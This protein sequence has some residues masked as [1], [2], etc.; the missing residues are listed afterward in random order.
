MPEED[1]SPEALNTEQRSRIRHR[2]REKLYHRDSKAS[3]DSQIR[4]QEIQSFLRAPKDGRT[5]VTTPDLE[6][7]HELDSSEVR[8][9][10]S[11]TSPSPARRKTP[12]KPNLH[13]NFAATP[14]V[15][16]G[17][18]GDEAALPVT[19]LLPSLTAPSEAPAEASRNVVSQLSNTASQVLAVQ[20]QSSQNG[21]FRPRT[22]QRRSTGLR[23]HDLNEQGSEP[24]N[25][26]QNQSVANRTLG[27]VRAGETVKEDRHE[28]RSNSAEGHHSANADSSKH[29]ATVGIDWNIR[30]VTRQ[31]TASGSLRLPLP[32]PDISFTNSLTPL[33]S[34][35]PLRSSNVSL[36]LRPS[37]AAPSLSDDSS[38]MPG[39]GRTSENKTQQPLRPDPP[40]LTVEN[41]GLSLRNVAKGVSDDALLE[42]AAR[43]QPYCN[44]FLLGLSARTE[45]TLQQW[46]IAASWWFLKGRSELE[47][48]VRARPGSEITQADVPL[49]LRQAYV[50]LAK[51]WW[52]ISEITP[53]RHPEVKR[54]E[55][56]GPVPISAIMQSFVDAKAA[57][58]IQMHLSILS[59]MRALTMSMK[60]NS[61]LPPHGLELQGLDTR[62]FVE[63][64]LLSPSAA[65]L[66]SIENLG[67]IS[68]GMHGE[69]AYT[70][71]IPITDTERHF[72]Y[73]QMF[74][75]VILDQDKAE[76]RISMPCV[77]SVVRD[78]KERDITIVAASQDGQIH[79]VIQPEAHMALSWQDVHWQT[80]HRY[81]D[82]DLRAD[83]GV[84]IQF[85]DKDFRTVWGIHDYIRAVRKQS[86]STRHE[87]L[88]FERVLRS[89]Q[90]FDKRKEATQFPTEPIEGCKLRLFECFKVI[91]TGVGERKIHDGY[92][93]LVVTARKVKTLS[94]V[95]HSLGRQDPIVFS[96]LRD[97]HGAPALLL[98]T[99]KSSNDPSMVMSFQ[100]EADRELLYA[101]LNGTKLSDDENGS[102]TLSLKNCDIMTNLNCETSLSNRTG[103]LGSLAWKRLQ[104]LGRRG[105][106]LE[107]GGPT[108]RIC[109]ECDIGS[110]ADRINLGPGELQMRL[111]CDTVDRVDIL[112]APQTDMTACFAD[113]SLSE[114]QYEGLRQLLDSVTR[115][116]TLRVFNFGSLNDLHTFQTLITGFSVLFDGF[117]KSFAITRRRMVV[118]IYKR[119]EASTTRLQIVRHDKTFQ[120]VAFFRDFSHGSCMNFVLKSTDV[121]ESFSRSGTPHLCIV[122]AKFA[123]PKEETD[124]NHRFINLEMPEYPGEHDDITIGFETDHDRDAFSNALP[125]PAPKASEYY[126]SCTRA[127]HADDTLNTVRDVAPPLHVSTTFRYDTDPNDLIP[128]S[129]AASHNT[130][131]HVYSRITAPN[132]T[133]FES[134]LTSVLN[135]SCLAYSSG[136]SALHAAYVCLNPKRVSIGGGYHGSHGVL[137]IHQ[138]LCGTELL[139][140]DCPTSDLSSGDV[141]HLETPLNPTGE[142][143]NM[144]AYAEKAHSRG[145]VLLVDATFG[146]P[147]LQDPFEWDADIVMHSGTKYLGGHS[148]M[149][150]GVL[151]TK[152]EEWLDRLRNEREFLGCVM[153]NMESWLG[154][155]SL[156]TLDLRVK[157]QSENAGKLVQWLDICSNT[158]SE[159]EEAALVKAVVRSVQHASLQ[160]ED[161]HWLKKQMP[162]GFGPVFAFIVKEEWMARQLPSLLSLFHHA[163]SLGAVESLIEWRSMS[164]ET[165]DPRLLRV[166]VGIEDWEDLKADLSKAFRRLLDRG[167]VSC[168]P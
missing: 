97:E 83:F 37:L 134:V 17:E 129:D 144:K 82:I 105:Q 117:A 81:L 109:A 116:P 132:A 4:D 98:R 147:G 154:V 1:T 2:W 64:P 155:R 104:V 125:A 161:M 25:W 131:A 71:P 149:L 31:N 123:L 16:I 20:E 111:H 59:N 41:R 85:A 138:R 162:N 65:R 165:V 61:R 42:F 88:V 93:L 157:R 130:E 15:I 58:L 74:V 69:T 18:G 126:N 39:D 44:V 102:D 113:N 80:S 75:D 122:D 36:N 13:V 77:L 47:S 21:Y 100:Q 60:R 96:Y 121:F 140:L 164:D 159:D 115:S 19:E 9:L 89:F 35:Q 24:T 110:I 51:A 14:P 108:L 103:L 29:N 166:S 45:P 136:L 90:H 95:S 87:T 70:F 143:Y 34:P 168:V 68:S 142:A 57:E 30:G 53:A 146:P 54:L 23:D 94:S 133:R 8:S 66:L 46:V 7:P 128:A 6:L 84:Q 86:K 163:T 28:S 50:D 112:R 40:K 127:I 119:W 26:N 101:L 32:D 114:K 151:A 145:A 52:I 27:S 91:G 33:P 11:N 49:H 167:D 124:P 99:L 139:P 12:R 120:L 67:K 158:D 135:A 73:G 38:S 62:I 76:H 152:N 106:Q 156:R 79:L 63:Y 153:G 137:A 55:A 160:H 3:K 107:L 150:S 56:R 148:D 118:P 22:L 72:N 78:R 43:V 5:A 141:I 10:S 92:R 48:S